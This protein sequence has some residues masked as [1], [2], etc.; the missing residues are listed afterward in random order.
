MYSIHVVRIRYMYICTM[1]VVLCGLR[2]DGEREQPF[3]FSF[4]SRTNTSDLRQGK[5]EDRSYNRNLRSPPYASVCKLEKQRGRI[6]RGWMRM[7]NVPGSPLTCRCVSP[8]AWGANRR[9]V[10]PKHLCQCTLVHTK[11]NIRSRVAVLC[12][13]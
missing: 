5:A 10:S 13:L 8:K 6:C 1:Y 3:F 4:S 7:Y 11:Y 9:S 2:R 12:T